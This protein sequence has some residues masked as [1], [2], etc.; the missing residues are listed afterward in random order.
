MQSRT[1]ILRLI[2]TIKFCF[3]P[4]QCIWKLPYKGIAVERCRLSSTFS[5]MINSRRASRRIRPSFLR[6]IPSSFVLTQMLE[7][8]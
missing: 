8:K 1:L 6:F 2:H 4:F 5:Y 7:I 3:K